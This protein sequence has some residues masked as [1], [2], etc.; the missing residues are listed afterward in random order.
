MTTL[1]IRIS[2]AV[3]VLI[4][5]AFFFQAQR[6]N[7]LANEYEKLYD[8]GK[9]DDAFA[10]VEKQLAIAGKMF[11]FGRY[12]MPFSLNNLGNI[13]YGKN[14]FTQAQHYYALAVDAAESVFGKK[15]SK[16]LPLFENMV[17]LY[18]TTGD[19]DQAQEYLDKIELIKDRGR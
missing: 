18:K 8:A 7:S 16:L 12:Y 9:Y 4:A 14:D 2:L 19:H 6:W 1:A 15:N 10:V 17:R 13:Y 11:I 3:A 5:G